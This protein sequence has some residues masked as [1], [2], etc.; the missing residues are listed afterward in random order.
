MRKRP[1]FVATHDVS[2][3]ISRRAFLTFLAALPLASA[4]PA[5]A[6]TETILDHEL[7]LQ[8]LP[9]AQM[10]GGFTRPFQKQFGYETRR[11]S[12][13]EEIDEEEHLF[14]ETER[15][16][17]S[18]FTAATHGDYER[19][20]RVHEEEDILHTARKYV[21]RG[22]LAV[23]LGMCGMSMMSLSERKAGRTR[24]PDVYDPMTID[25]YFKLRPDKLLKRMALFAREI[26][27]IGSLFARDMTTERVERYMKVKDV[28]ERVEARDRRRAEAL[29]EAITRL[30]PAVIKLGQAAACRPDVFRTSV[31]RELQKLQ[32]DILEYFPTLDAIEVI[33]DELGAMP[34]VLFDYMTPHPIAGASLGMVF[35]A[36]LEKGTWVAVKVQRPEVAEQIALDCYIVRILASVANVVLRSRTDFRQAVDEYSSRL[37]EELDYRNELNNML[38]FR[39]LYGSVK[40]IYL[41]RVYEG[42]CSKRVL[43]TE[44]VEGV[45]IV[46]DDA[47]VRR[48]DLGLVE[49][50]I[51][52][53]LMQLL[54]RGFLHADMHNGN[55]K[56]VIPNL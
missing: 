23:V 48:E 54:D 3:P 19:V 21:S 42:F 37:F 43:V 52:F 27:Y 16:A 50:G 1:R 36:R 24:L 30:G 45:K 40:G 9:D 22:L 51:R 29:R 53:A 47:R 26:L 31:I 4:F 10:G 38:K 8:T 25:R 5:H 14:S 32:D 55:S 41:P 28:E 33:Y 35:R 13:G 2:A 20:L 44:W 39:K 15:D 12:R 49:T 7:D 56:F 6:R 46:D 11:G 34:H 17:D 18:S